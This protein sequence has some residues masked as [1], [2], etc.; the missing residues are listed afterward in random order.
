MG[1]KITNYLPDFLYIFMA[2]N[3]VGGPGRLCVWS[4]ERNR[5]QNFDSTT[6]ETPQQ[7]NLVFE[8]FITLFSRFQSYL[9]ALKNYQ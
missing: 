4:S 9:L 1:G 2:F 8:T 3:K 6:K 5:A 7:I